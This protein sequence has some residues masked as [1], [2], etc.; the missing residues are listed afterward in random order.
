MSLTK[1]SFSMINT[2]NLTVEDFGAVGDGVTNDAAALQLAFNYS[3]ANNVAI[4]LQDKRYYTATTLQIGNA[5]IRSLSGQ[6]GSADPYYLLSPTGV[7]VLGSTPNGN[8]YF[9]R[10]A[11]GL[12]FTFA[13]MIAGTAYGCCIVSDFNGNILECANGKRINIQGFA[14]VGFHRA[15]LQ[16]GI[17]TAVPTVYAGANHAPIRDIT[18]IGTG[19][20]GIWFKRGLENTEMFNVQVRFC[21]AQG[22][23]VGITTGVDCPVDNLAF[24]GC[25]FSFNRLNG[26]YFQEIRKHLYVNN[27]DFSGNGQYQD[28][29]QNDGSWID[30]LLGYD[31]QP[32]TNVALMAAGM[33]IY[34]SSASYAGGFI[35]DICLTNITGEL[36]ACGLHLRSA[37]GIAAIQFL[38]I[39]NCALYRSP[40]FPYS[41]GNNAALIFLNVSYLNNSLM[42][43][44]DRQA[45]DYISFPSG[46]PP[47]SGNTINSNLFLD[48]NIT[49]NASAALLADFISY[50]FP[51]AIGVQ[52]TTSKIYSGIT[53]PEGVVIAPL[54]SIYLR[55]NGGAG[56]SFYVKETGAGNTGWVG[57]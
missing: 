19:N 44:N 33:Q 10:N 3:A 28:G 15:T 26:L 20:N 45:C 53:S 31:R 49:S 50:R 21:N 17:A 47:T 9:D 13:Q 46:I 32:P 38:R 7:P 25:Q 35:Q 40:Q 4:F 8:Y 23:A 36:V 57:K 5:I 43:Q 55:T 42:S 52:G 18:V 27:S 16:S 12:A 14:V 30:P 51:G 37:S 48:N 29:Q 6:P 54:G 39:Q 1:V 34:D 56:T 41:G 22:F 24:E 2:T 11:Q